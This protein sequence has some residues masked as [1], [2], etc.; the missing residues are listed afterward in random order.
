MLVKRTQCALKSVTLAPAM[1]SHQMG[2]HVAAQNQGN[3]TPP[4]C[5]TGITILWS[6]YGSDPCCRISDV[7]KSRFTSRVRRRRSSSGLESERESHIESQK[8]VRPP[9]THKSSCHP[10][11]SSTQE[12]KE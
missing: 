6:E 5:R 4:P 10:D 3:S 7:A 12:G 8:Q 11:D 2:S 9:R 1:T